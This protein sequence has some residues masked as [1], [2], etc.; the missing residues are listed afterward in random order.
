MQ[1]NIKNA[2]LFL[3][4][5]NPK[6]EEQPKDLNICEQ[7]RGQL[8]FINHYLTCTSCGLTDLD[9]T[10]TCYMESYDEYIYQRKVYTRESYMHL[11]KLEC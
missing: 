7:Y 2:H 6:I 5:M 8:Q 4:E 1:L 11:I 3:L 9:M 10:D